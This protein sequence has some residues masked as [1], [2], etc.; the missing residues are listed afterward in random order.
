MQKKMT[1]EEMGPQM[2]KSLTGDAELSAR[3]PLVDGDS[4][5]R[6]GWNRPWTRASAPTSRCS[7]GATAGEF[8]MVSTMLPAALDWLPRG[9]ALRMSG[10]TGARG[11]AYAAVTPGKPRLLLGR[12][13]TD[14]TFRFCV[15]RTLAARDR[16]RE[17]AHASR[18]TSASPTRTTASPATASSCRSRGTRLE[19]DNVAA[20]AG[21]NPPQHLADTAHAAWVAF[22]R[23]GDPGWPSYDRT[24]RQGMVFDHK[25]QATAVY[26]RESDLT[27]ALAG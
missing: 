17:A 12:I 5:A 2:V 3:A 7:A 26:T 10:L 25:S 20:S 1:D 4:G 8:E 13:M 24:E 11:K 19:S 6:T 21:P 27:A 23:D 9:L 14:Y 16:N 15:V 22:I 18:T